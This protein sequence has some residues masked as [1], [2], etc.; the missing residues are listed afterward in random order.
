[1]ANL[2]TNN[3]C[4][5]G[6]RNAING[7]VFFDGVRSYLQLDG[8]SEFA[9]GTTDF[10]IEM[11][12]KIDDDT[13]TNTFYDSRPSGSNGAQI[14]LF[15]SGSSNAV[16]FAQGGSVR[17]TGT[18]DV[19]KDHAWHHIVLA[20]QSGSTKLFVNGIQ[21]GSTYSD[22][23]SYEN[24]AN[25]PFIGGSSGSTHLA[26]G[27][28][29]KGYISN[30]RVCIGHAVY[31]S[32]FTP[33]SSPLKPHF[34]SVTDKSALL[35]CQNSDN[36]IQDNSVAVPGE[37]IPKTITAVGSPDFSHNPDNLIKNGRFTYS[38]DA[39]W[40]LTGGTAALG[41]GQSGV[42]N[43]GNH[44]VLTA[45]SSY[46]YLVQAFTTKIGRT[47]RV[48]CQSNGGDASFISTTSSESDAI[49]TDI[50]STVQTTDGRVAEKNFNAE[51]TTY[52][53]ILRASTGGGNFDTASAY[54]EEN[55]FA[56]QPKV[57]PPFGT[58]DGVT[59][60]GA[61]SMNSSGYMCFPTG[62]TEER[63]R[64]RMLIGGG[65]AYPSENATIYSINIQ[66]QGNTVVFGDLTQA[67]E[68]TAAV[69]S[70][71]RAVFGGG[72]NFGAPDYNI[73]DYVEFA[74]TGNA[75]D[76]GDL[77]YTARE[78]QGTSNQT[79]GVIAGGYF[80]P[81]NTNSDTMDYITIASIGN[82]TDFGNLTSTWREGHRG[83]ISNGSRGIFGSGVTPSFINDINYITIATTGNAQ[84]FGDLL[85]A[86]RQHGGAC[87]T[88]RGVFA[89]EDLSPSGGTNTIQ[90]I[91]IASTGNAIDFGDMSVTGGQHAG[92][93]NKIRGVF[94]G[95]T[96]AS[97]PYAINI[98]SYVT[99]ATT[100]N[101]ADFGDISE[102]LS[103]AGAASDCHGG[104]S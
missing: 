19:G 95:G 52:Y 88:T 85:N 68:G 70:V 23:T 100:G 37:S 15:Y 43:D 69:S 78:T 16:L 14:A 30:V 51:Q 103:Y 27:T 64:G 40:T 47:Y 97:S 56:N 102:Q 36:P 77:N 53:M 33:P 17:I 32:N 1:M 42:F 25:R 18:T 71:T 89:G 82:A 62:R 57:N 9:F 65:G 60:D 86:G 20:R 73:L 66:S 28:Y 26:A 93:S 13:N 49:I 58:D 81:S 2:R 46:A 84:D 50:R 80:S 7:S 63:G 5:H 67:R 45:S 96:Q 61:V 91:T 48:N 6:G 10:T 94:A 90:Y 38:A 39:E 12:I 21:E 59:F 92:G 35:C 31:F 34:T 24:P 101:A 75:L 4:G 98:I 44:L 8:S 29:M 55:V 79:R 99:I 76:F 104:L 54:E 11:W 83:I 41:T 74:T 87:S 3:L 22:S 72:G